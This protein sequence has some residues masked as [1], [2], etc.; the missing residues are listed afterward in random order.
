[1]SRNFYHTRSFIILIAGLIIAIC[2][3]LSTGSIYIPIS[4]IFD[5]LIGN[6]SSKSSWQYIILNYRIPKTLT[7]ILVGS[8]LSTAGLLMQ[9]MFKNPLAG[10]YVLGISSGASLGVALLILG[11]SA[12]GITTIDQSQIWTTTLAAGLGSM[13]VLILIICISN[14]IKDTMALLIIGLMLGSLT[15]AIVSILAY[16]SKAEEL[17]QFIFWS[18][19]SIGNNSWEELKILSIILSVG[20]LIAITALKNLNSLLLGDNY[21]SSLGVS[22]IKSRAIILLAASILAG[23]TT[24]FAGPI[25]FI[26]LAVPHLVRQLIPTANHF[27]QFPAVIIGGSILMLLC[28]TIAQVPF[29]TYTLPINAITSIVGAPIVI[30]LL[31][32]KKKL[33]F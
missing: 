10:P 21:A 6:E 30:W 29:S 32:R 24:A 1:M 17:Q 18:F 22:F 5:I 16:F 8:S 28:D 13:A 4:E 7:A 9:T 19:G 20:F 2:I 23:C 14:Y 31:V 33:L 12:L 26:G 27:I 15:G 25:A 11:S 3:S